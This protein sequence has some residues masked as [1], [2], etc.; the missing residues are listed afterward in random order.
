MFIC[1]SFLCNVLYR[2]I[3]VFTVFRLLTDFV[4]LYTYE[5]WLSPLK[6]YPYLLYIIGCLFSLYCLSSVDVKLLITSLVLATISATTLHLLSR[7]SI[8]NI[9]FHVIMFS[10]V[11]NSPKEYILTTIM[12]NNIKN[13]Q[14]LGVL[15]IAVDQCLIINVAM[16]HYR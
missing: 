16:F 5:F 14:R 4:C 11:S 7:P 6:D 2:V 8:G 13:E 10:S 15:H 9:V 12:K 1:F 3:T